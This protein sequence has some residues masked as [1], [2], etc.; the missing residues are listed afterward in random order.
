LRR[1][2]PGGNPGGFTLFEVIVF[3]ALTLV[4][5]GLAAG[6][7]VP[8]L[9]LSSRA[10][11][12][13]EMQQQA[14]AALSR[15][16]REAQLT[17]VGGLT[18]RTTSP[19]VALAINPLKEVQ[20]DGTMIWDTRFI[21]YFCEGGRLVRRQWPP[22]PPEQTPD[23]SMEGRAKRL[24]GERLLQVVEPLLSSTSPTPAAL[25]YNVVATGVTE[26]SIEAGGDDAEVRQP[27][28]FRLTLQRRGNLGKEDN[29]ETFTYSRTVYLRNQRP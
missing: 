13:I 2:F 28:Q 21:V 5:L 24:S 12:K 17:S 18:L 9:R 16:S 29:V 6:F 8:A 14:V 7:L 27:I 10:S 4:L 20:A 23:E 26:F 22:G 1:P 11:L 15:L 25:D 3:I 19:P